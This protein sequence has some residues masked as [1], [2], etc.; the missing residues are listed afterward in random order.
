VV[1]DKEGGR[2]DASDQIT[3]DKIERRTPSAR[4]HQPPGVAAS[5]LLTNQLKAGTI[6]VGML[7]QAVAYLVVLVHLAFIVFVVLGGALALRWRWIPWVHVPAV[8][9]GALLE[10]CGWMCPLTPLENWLR[11]AGGASEYPE[12]FLEQYILPV[13]Y[14]ATLTRDAQVALGLLVCLVNAAVYLHLWRSRAR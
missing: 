6:V 12:G 5:A 9:W 13:V 10:F 8:L 1:Y 14:P 11:R 2:V 3:F 7:F 4:R